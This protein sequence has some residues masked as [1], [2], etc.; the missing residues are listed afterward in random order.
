MEPASAIISRSTVASKAN[1]EVKSINRSNTK[2]SQ[3]SFLKIASSL[4][5]SFQLDLNPDCMA[6]LKE[7]RNP[8]AAP[9]L[10]VLPFR[11]ERVSPMTISGLNTPIF[12]VNQELGSLVP[13]DSSP[14]LDSGFFGGVVSTGSLSSAPLNIPTTSAVVDNMMSLSCHVLTPCALSDSR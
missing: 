13:A 3:N 8:Q 5:Q 11:R 9:F 12:S 4:V 10:S 6:T 14:C 7:G 2:L 1:R